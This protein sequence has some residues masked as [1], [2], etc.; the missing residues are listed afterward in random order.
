MISTS[1]PLLEM[2]DLVDKISKP[3]EVALDQNYVQIGIRSHGKGL[4]DKPQV[5]GEALGNK[6]VFWVEPDCFVV[7]IVFAWEQAVGRT[8]TDDHGKIASHRFPMFKP[9]DNKADVE[10]LNYLFKT[11]L[12]KHLLT[13]A[14][15]GGAGRNKTLGQSE[16]LKIKIPCPD[17]HEQKRI[18]EILS[19]WDRAIEITEKL[20]ANSEAQK[21]ALMQKLLTGKERLPGF[22]EK[23][24]KRKLQEIVEIVYGSS[25]KGVQDSNGRYPIIGTGGI[26][27]RT[28]EVT[29]NVPSVII[30]RKGTIDRPQLVEEPFWAIDTTYFC[31][32][33]ECDLNWLF[34]IF[35][36]LNWRK[37]N[38]A[39]GVPSLS[40]ETL[41]SI[42]LLVPDLQEQA[43]IGTMLSAVDAEILL[44]NKRLLALEKEKSALMQQLLT[45]KRRVKIDKEA[46]A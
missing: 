26:V 15:P 7:N 29:C 3:V 45:G 18:A 17:V 6:R 31:R 14:S 40:R 42:S 43:E 37:Y 4:F 34:Q 21:K 9:K 24:N 1:F 16:F 22:S 28:N 41:Y 39:S 12:G 36:S 23:W 10:Y 20:I 5:S 2:E 32:P 13:L 19:T 27:G 38:E 8:S 35:S 33:R 11:K 44:Q 25:P 46:A 30:G